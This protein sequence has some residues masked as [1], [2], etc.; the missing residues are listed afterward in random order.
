MDFHSFAAGELAAL[1]R[2]LADAV[3]ARVEHATAA[4]VDAVRAEAAVA[5][6]QARADADVA[7]AEVRADAEMAIARARA[8]ADAMVAHARADAEERIARL[9]AEAQEEL[10]RVRAEHDEA[11]IRV[12]ADAGE[13]VT[14]ARSSHDDAVAQARQEAE[15]AFAVFRVSA[16]QEIASLREAADAAARTS[17]AYGAMIDKLRTQHAQLAADNE[18]LAAENAALTYER[19]DLLARAEAPHR[20]PLLEQLAIAFAAIGTARTVDAMLAAAAT[21]LAAGV[22]RVAAFAVHDGRLV[23]ACAHGADGAELASLPY[24]GDPTLAIMAPVLVRGE[25][26]GVLYADAGGRPMMDEAASDHRQ[27]AELLRAHCELRLERLLVESRANTELEA[28]AQ[29]LLD[30]IEYGYDADAAA[31]RSEQERARRMRENLQCA[32]QIYQQRV[33]HEG[34]AAVSLLDAVIAQTVAQK[35]TKMFGRTL[36]LA[37]AGE[38]AAPLAMVF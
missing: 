34:P 21:P 11:L 7:L 30:E 4:A 24:A 25:R 18:Q 38:P 23:P 36:Q 14:A 31:G 19:A 37:V 16:D 26:H 15:A 5:L 28:Y 12:K 29:M 32:R 10:A 20:G 8:D 1:A 27:L 22:P 9:R 17:A 3:D 6:A 13:A 33:V 35:A 2:T